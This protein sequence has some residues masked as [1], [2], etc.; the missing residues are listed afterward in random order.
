MNLATLNDI[1]KYN[2]KLNIDASLLYKEHL[3]ETEWGKLYITNSDVIDGIAYKLYGSYVLEDVENPLETNN[4]SELLTELQF[5]TDM[6][7]QAYKTSINKLWELESINFSP[8]E[9]YDRYETATVNKSGNET[10]NT[11]KSGSKI[12]TSTSNGSV[13]NESKINQTETN[14]VEPTSYNTNLVDTSKTSYS[15]D[16]DTSKTTYDNL[17]NDNKEVYNNITENNTRTY[18]DVRDTTESHIHG[19]IG[20]TTATAMMKEYVDFYSTYNFWLKF[21]E[22]YVHINCRADFNNIVEL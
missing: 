4:T 15:G 9:N 1:K 11:I 12:N 3:T 13:S 8:I 2:K 16:A 19:N 14:T 17:V 7:I 6:F 5:N 22:L 18:N 10:D 21:W 20:V